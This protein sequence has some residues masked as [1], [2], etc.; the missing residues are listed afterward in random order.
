MSGESLN[1]ED[2]KISKSQF[3]QKQK[4]IYDRRHRY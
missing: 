2:E 1:F 4:T 3:L